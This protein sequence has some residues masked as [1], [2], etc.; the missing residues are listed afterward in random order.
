MTEG[1]I[2]RQQFGEMVANV[3][4]LL[5]HQAEVKGELLR[6]QK[7]VRDALAAYQDKMQVLYHDSN[8][9]IFDKLDAVE[10]TVSDVQVV[11]AGIRP[12]IE[13]HDKSIEALKSRPGRVIEIGS[14]LI[15]AVSAI[16]AW[17]T[18]RGH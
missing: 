6:N 9:R 3:K 10:G 8:K 14:A 15:A 13:Q 18:V 1:D 2:D 5:A 12:V 11:L 7:E 16:V 17:I 4:T